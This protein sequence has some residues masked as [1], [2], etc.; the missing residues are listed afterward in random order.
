MICFPILVFHTVVNQTLFYHIKTGP[1]T[2]TKCK[3]DCNS[4]HNFPALVTSI[5]LDRPTFLSRRE[6]II[7][8]LYDILLSLQ[9]ETETNI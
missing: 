1:N 6:I 4:D 2:L 5:L 9:D 7:I 8:H 3:D